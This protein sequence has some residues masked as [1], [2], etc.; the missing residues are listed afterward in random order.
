M[1]LRL[2]RKHS[3]DD[4]AG[5]SKRHNVDWPEDEGYNEDEAETVESDD[6]VDDGSDEEDANSVDDGDDQGDA[7]IVDD[8]PYDEAIEAFPARPAF[9]KELQILDERTV[10]LAR[11]LRKTLEEHSS[12]S[13]TLQNMKAKLDEAVQPPNPEQLMVAMV[14][15]TGAGK[16][17]RALISCIVLNIAVTGKSSSLNAVTDTPQLAK[18]VCFSRSHE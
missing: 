9:D 13:E 18:A 10:S 11:M 2:K 1:K 6:E 14:G 15:A 3:D 8:G 4:I 17:S 16:T 7:S 5:P 12:V